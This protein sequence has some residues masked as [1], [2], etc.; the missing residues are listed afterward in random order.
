MIIMIIYPFFCGIHRDWMGKYVGASKLALKPKCTQQVSEILK[1][2]NT[3]RL[4]VVPQGGNTGLVGGRCALGPSLQRS[5]HVDPAGPAGAM[6]QACLLLLVRSLHARL[7]EPP[8][9]AEHHVCM[10][11]RLCVSRGLRFACSSCSVPVHDE[12][13]LS[14]T[15][16][17]NIISFDKVGQQLP[18][19]G[20]GSTVSTEPTPAC[21]I[22]A[23]SHTSVPL[24]LQADA[25]TWRVWR[26]P[27]WAQ[28]YA[29]ILNS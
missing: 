8:V 26:A 3:R 18:G 19:P 29:G 10:S 9:Q 11:W 28:A 5:C 22:L 27:S 14:T 24:W 4:A 13:V 16:L 20:A 23:P 12:V 17:N 1:Y 15:A 25:G 6:L 21:M 7:A 2:C